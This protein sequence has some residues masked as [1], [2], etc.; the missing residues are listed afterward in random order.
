MMRSEMRFE[1]VH[2][3]TRAGGGHSS[4]SWAPPNSRKFDGMST[5]REE[6][7]TSAIDGKVAHVQ[8][9]VAVP[10]HGA[11]NLYPAWAGGP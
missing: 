10:A 4:A 6:L 7:L 8:L 9:D 1:G 2:C 11:Q 5:T 3:E